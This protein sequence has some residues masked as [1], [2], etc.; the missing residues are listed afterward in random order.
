MTVSRLLLSVL[1]IASLSGCYSMYMGS[2]HMREQ[3]GEIQ[4]KRRQNQPA[5]STAVEY[6]PKQVPS[7]TPTTS[8]NNGEQ[9]GRL[10][11]V[12]FEDA[13]T[14]QTY[15]VADVSKRDGV[16]DNP[17]TG[18]MRRGGGGMSATVIRQMYDGRLLVRGQKA[19]PGDNAGYV[20]L[21]GIVDPGDINSDGV[22]LSNRVIEARLSYFGG[23]SARPPEVAELARFFRGGGNGGS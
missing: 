5:S 10:L 21:D 6:A 17:L 2:L 3:I 9:V 4:E 18:W 7:A 19:L 11:R 23:S 1:L 15:G 8:G 13:S 12:E 20:Q 16:L 22:V 14:V